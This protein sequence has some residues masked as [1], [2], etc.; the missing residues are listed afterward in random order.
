MKTMGNDRPASTESAVLIPRCFHHAGYLLALATLALAVTGC[1]KDNGGTSIGAPPPSNAT[2]GNTPG[3][4]LQIALVPKGTTQS[5]WQTVKAGAEQ[6]GK[7]ENANIIFQGPTEET[8]IPGQKNILEAQITKKVDAIVMA[9]CDAKAL[10]PTVQKAQAAGIPVITIDSGITPDTSVQFI[11]TD[12]KKG[13]A[14][15]ADKLSELIGTDGGDVGLIPFIPGAGSSDDRENGF[16]DELKKYPKLNLASTLYSQSDVNTAQNVTNQMVAS[17]PNLKG[18][19]AAN[20]AG[21]IGSAQALKLKGLAGKIKLVAYDAGDAEIEALKAGTIQALI[22]QRPFDMGYKGVKAAVEAI[23]AG[24]VKSD[25]PQMEDTGVTVVT[26]E[27][28]N[29]PDIQKL[30]FPLGSH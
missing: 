4:T 29:Q 5:Y 26:M 15:A 20:Q 17:H 19:F 2:A 14:A 1:P 7:E 9:A 24:K 13:G 10:V 23:K 18:I 11:A 25:T 22:V 27:N 6:A 21:G 28:F 3:K 12:N 16:K 30:L 8:D